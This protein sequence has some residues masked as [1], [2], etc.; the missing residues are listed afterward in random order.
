MNYFEIKR[1]MV[2]LYSILKVRPKDKEAIIYIK[3]IYRF[4]NFITSI[5]THLYRLLLF[6]LFKWVILFSALYNLSESSCSF[7]FLSSR[8]RKKPR[9]KQPSII[10]I[11]SFSIFLTSYKILYIFEIIATAN[12]I[13]SSRLILA[14]RY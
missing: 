7:F 4:N 9:S 14:A 5:Y 12:L 3:T 13:A 11:I 8:H 10:S 6:K 1:R 2:E